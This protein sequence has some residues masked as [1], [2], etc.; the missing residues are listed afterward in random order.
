MTA[1][2][3]NVIDH[4]WQDS[5]N[6][7]TVLKHSFILWNI[8]FQQERLPFLWLGGKF[9]LFK[10]KKLSTPMFKLFPFSIIKFQNCTNLLL[11]LQIFAP[12]CLQ[13]F[14]V[15]FQI[16]LFMRKSFFLRFLVQHNLIVNH[17]KCGFKCFFSVFVDLKVGFFY[18]FDWLWPFFFLFLFSCCH[19][20]SPGSI[21]HNNQR[22]FYWHLIF[23]LKK[24]MK[25][26][27]HEYVSK[28]RYIMTQ[29]ETSKQP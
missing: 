17:G 15:Q 20:V 13:Y 4:N 5:K 27:C 26:L 6:L 16:T 21:W 11:V 25:I 28:L 1:T 7:S 3:N 22:Q 18:E 24:I 9:K 12:S 2:F 10:Y 23:S 19:I 14:V 8:L 29:F